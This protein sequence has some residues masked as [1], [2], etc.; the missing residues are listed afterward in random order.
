[1]EKLPTVIE[2]IEQYK[3]G[4]LPQDTPVFKYQSTRGEGYIHI[5]EL[6]NEIILRGIYSSQHKDSLMGAKTRSK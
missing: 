6:K 1:M 2:L 3:N 4:T 5:D